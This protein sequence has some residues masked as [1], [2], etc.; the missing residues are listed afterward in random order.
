MTDVR[1]GY[2]AGVLVTPHS[3]TPGGLHR[4]PGAPRPRPHL[5]QLPPARGGES[6]VTSERVDVIRVS[7]NIT[8]LLNI[9]WIK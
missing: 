8:V 4:R 7:R 5:T 9:P 1:T 6:I 2:C 3:C